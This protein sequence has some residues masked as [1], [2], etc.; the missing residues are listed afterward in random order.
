MEMLMGI[1]QGQEWWDLVPAIVGGVIG[2]LA[3]GLPAWFLANKASKEAFARDKETRLQQELAAGFKIF[4]KLSVMVND[5]AST[6]MQIEEMLERPFDPN[7]ESPTQRRI[8]AFAGANPEPELQFTADDLY[9]LVAAKETDYLTELDLFGR[10]YAANVRSLHT[11][12]LLK[13][14][15]HDTIASSEDVLFLPGDAIA[16]PAQGPG[17]VR[18]RLQARTLESLIVAL[19]ENFRKDTA[20]GVRLAKQFY[21]KMKGYFKDQAVPGFEFT[22]LPS[23]VQQLLKEDEPSETSSQELPRA[24][25]RSGGSP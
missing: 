4:S 19:I 18:L 8:S 15:L 2:A 13:A 20:L 16:T 24:D 7:D 12:G 21:P 6:L 22:E 23:S 3:G 25:N 14:K 5:L 10:R 17:A 9:V 11:Y 1:I